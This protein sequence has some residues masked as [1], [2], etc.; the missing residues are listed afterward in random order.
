MPSLFIAMLLLL[1]GVISA[2]CSVYFHTVLHFTVIIPYLYL[3]SNV[4]LYSKLQD[5]GCT[6]F[7]LSGPYLHMIIKWLFPYSLILS[8]DHLL[9]LQLNNLN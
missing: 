3:Y 7:H 4:F 9:D 6:I 8:L 2:Y 5:S 1:F